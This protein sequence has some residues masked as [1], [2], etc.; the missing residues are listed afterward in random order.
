[1]ESHVVKIYRSER[2]GSSILKSNIEG[3]RRACTWRDFII[4][5]TLGRKNKGKRERTAESKAPTTQDERQLKTPP[6]PL[7]EDERRDQRW[8]ILS[9][10]M[11][12]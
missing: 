3:D 7:N 2:E 6:N 11:K 5:T 1:M 12:C 10:L 9:S 4:I 8:P